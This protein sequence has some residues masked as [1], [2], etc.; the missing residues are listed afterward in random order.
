[1]CVMIFFSVNY[2]A[3]KNVCTGIKVE[4]QSNNMV[5]VLSKIHISI[6]EDMLF[7]QTNA[8]DLFLDPSILQ[9]TIS[10]TKDICVLLITL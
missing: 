1:M 6:T 2:I 3:F 9:F 4:A 8:S 5:E 7:M 10:K